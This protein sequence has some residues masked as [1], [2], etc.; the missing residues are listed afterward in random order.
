[1]AMLT[2]L[3]SRTDMNMPTIRTQSGPIQLLPVSAAAGAGAGTGGCGRSA[4]GAAPGPDGC[5]AGRGSVRVVVG[6]AEPS[7]V[8]RPVVA[9]LTS[10]R[11]ADG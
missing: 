10:S 4:G 11:Y 2:M 6:R 8:V 7:S 3:V 1:M 9:V 5:V